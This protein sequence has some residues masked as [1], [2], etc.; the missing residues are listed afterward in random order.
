M[1]E[2]GAHDVCAHHPFLAAILAGEGKFLDLGDGQL[3]GIFVRL[4]EAGISG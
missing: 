1:G 4:D 2:P 3:Y